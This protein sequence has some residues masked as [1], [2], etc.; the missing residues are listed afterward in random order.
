MVSRPLALTADPA[1]VACSLSLQHGRT[2]RGFWQRT[3]DQAAAAGDKK[4]LMLWRRVVSFL[5][6]F[7]K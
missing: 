6:E 7:E 2:W 4:A 5:D 1:Q 3:K